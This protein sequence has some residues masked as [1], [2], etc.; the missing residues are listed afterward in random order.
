MDISLNWQ[1]VLVTI[2]GVTFLLRA[3]MAYR[4]WRIR[5]STPPVRKVKQSK[6][7]ELGFTDGASKGVICADCGE[8]TNTYTSYSDS[9]FRCPTCSPAFSEGINNG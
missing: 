5:R 6:V 4:R 7:H 1:E 8:G 9:T 3:E 2:I